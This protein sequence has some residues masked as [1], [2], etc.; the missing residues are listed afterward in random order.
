MT[1][2]LTGD[3]LTVAEVVRVAR[4]G[5]RV[6]LDAGSVERMRHA[7]ATVDAA[8]ARGEGIYGLTVGVGSRARTPVTPADLDQFNRLLLLNH[9][10]AQGPAAPEEVVRAAMVRLANGFAKGT[11]VARPELAQFVVSALNARRH[12]RVRLLGSVGEGDVAPMVDLAVGLLDGFELALGEGLVVFSNNAFSNGLAALA[13]ADCERLIEAVCVAGAL[14]M[15]AFAANLDH[16]DAAI[17]ESRPYPGL[18]ATI[19]RLR[20]LMDGSYLWEPGT[21]RH[22]QDP[23]TFRCFPQVHGAVCDALSFASAQVTIEL[24]A[25]QSN[26]LVVASEGRVVRVGNFEVLPLAA[27]LDFLRI[28]LAS[29][30]TSA[31]ER[32]VKLLQAP[33]TGLPDGLAALPG[34]PECGIAELDRAAYALA[35][36]ARLLAQP[37][38]FELSGTSIS[39]GY[40]DRMNMAPLAARRLAEMVE[41]GG[42]IVAI[43]LVIAAQAVELRHK[44]ALG[45]GTARALAL[46]RERVPFTRQG[47]P[48]P[49]DLE[50]VRDLVQS[51]ALSQ[52]PS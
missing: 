30:L 44:P 35:A 29:T 27:A 22:F 52:I 25:A 21:A 46:V 45:K 23:F 17:A 41:L 20:A 4:N 26:P 24:N 11:T 12:P 34:L 18:Q 13:I 36:E 49:Q 37:V 6:E 3:C 31:A 19:S 50:P 47:E 38:S 10:V 39:E 40:E 16:I 5:E 43:E 42:R 15:E 33:M 51:G 32:A 2:V 1:V 7:R 48:V 14:D 28:A 9:R 8:I